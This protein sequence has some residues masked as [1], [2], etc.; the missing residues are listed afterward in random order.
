MSDPKKLTLSDV[1]WDLVR[2]FSAQGN[3][4]HIVTDEGPVVFEFA[5]EAEA[6]RA[7]EKWFAEYRK[8]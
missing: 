1:V 2:M 4:V 5:S 7:I 6:K 8:G 3:T